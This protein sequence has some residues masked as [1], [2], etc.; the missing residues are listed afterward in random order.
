MHNSKDEEYRHRNEHYSQNFGAVGTH[1]T[2][3]IDKP[4]NSC[5]VKWCPTLNVHIYFFNAYELPVLISQ[6]PKYYI[7]PLN[8]P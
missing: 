8:G 3:T 7:L 6:N 5:P 2:D 1:K 4:V